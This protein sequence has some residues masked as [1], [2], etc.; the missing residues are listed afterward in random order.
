M[1]KEEEKSIKEIMYCY[2]SSV[3]LFFRNFTPEILCISY[4]LNW[5][6]MKQHSMKSLKKSAAVLSTGYF[7]F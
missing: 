4:C 2:I 3:I 5:K 1:L 6:G 7:I